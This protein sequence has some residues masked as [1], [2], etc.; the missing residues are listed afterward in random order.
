MFYLLSGSVQ[1]MVTVGAEDRTNK[2]LQ[3]G[4]KET[5]EEEEERDEEGGGGGGQ[6]RLHQLRSP[7]KQLERHRR[8]VAGF[9]QKIERELGEVKHQLASRSSQRKRT[10]GVVASTADFYD[11]LGR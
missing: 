11:E 2:D 7:R 6:G 4:E 10:E 8:L 5:Q 1:K 9:R 3:Y